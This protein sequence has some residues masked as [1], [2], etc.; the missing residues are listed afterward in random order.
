MRDTTV[1]IFNCLSFHFQVIHGLL[2]AHHTTTKSREHWMELVC[3]ETTRVFYDRLTDEKD[4][5]IFCNIVARALKDSF[6][7]KWRPEKYGVDALL[8]GDFLDFNAG[9]YDRLYRCVRDPKQLGQVLE[10][11]KTTVTWEVY[12]FNPKNAK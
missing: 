11:R 8:F 1:S 3:H 7:V 4:R 6:K 9:E 12:F 2:Q 5:G 10:V